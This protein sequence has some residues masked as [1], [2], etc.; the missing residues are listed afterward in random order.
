MFGRDT[1]PKIDF[2]RQNQYSNAIHMGSSPFFMQSGRR[3]RIFSI[4][5]QILSAMSKKLILIAFFTAASLGLNSQ[6]AALELTFTAVNIGASVRLDSIRVMNRTRGGDTVLYYP[7]NL[8][9]LDYQ[10]GI[11]KIN[12]KTHGLQV[13]QNYPNPVADQTIISLFVPE[14]DKVSLTVTD[15]LGRMIIQT[16]RMLEQGIHSFRF[17]PGTASLYFFTARWRGTS[18]GI[19]IVHAALHNNENRMEYLGSEA[20]LPELKAADDIQGFSFSPGD[21]LLFAGYSDT[22]QSGMLDDP[23]ANENYTF[24][25][26]TNI[27]CPGTPTVEYEGKVY[28]TI[29]I[30]SQCW[31]KENLNV[32]TMINS[33][34]DMTDNGLIEKYCHDNVASRC[35]SYGGLYRWGELMQYIIEQGARGICPPGWH[36]PTDE[37]W[38][39]LEGTVDST[40]GIGDPEWDLDWKYRGD[41]AGTNLKETYD[42]Y[43]DGD[44]T[45]L[46][47]FSA[48]PG[49]F[50]WPVDSFGGGGEFSGYKIFTY[51]WTSTETPSHIVWSRDLSSYYPGVYRVARVKGGAYSV[52]CLRD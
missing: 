18:S 32:G 49:G 44:G 20:S 3:L 8:L 51:F 46:F 34:Q 4:S 33:N 1:P 28:H 12:Q 43:L 23:E 9:V 39:V 13:F 42:W 6:H 5:N 38:K 26:A 30:F 40:H 31:M 37:E 35:N 22:L 16:E 24:Q 11:E 27:P 10:L 50:R 29:Q 52:R 2:N 19:K 47:G 15:F 7:N 17:T 25:F 36:I 41:D 14:K 45:D 21:L 48:L